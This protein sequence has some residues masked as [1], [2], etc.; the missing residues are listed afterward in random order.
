M[1]KNESFFFFEFSSLAPLSG[2][3]KK[4]RKNC[5]FFRRLSPSLPRKLVLCYRHR[6]RAQIPRSTIGGRIASES[7]EKGSFRNGEREKKNYH[8]ATP[9]SFSFIVVDVVVKRK[10]N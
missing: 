8:A 5:S 2:L 10:K 1:K 3:S 9:T 7:G 6:G 4:E